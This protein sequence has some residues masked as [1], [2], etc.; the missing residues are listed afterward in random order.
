MPGILCATG[1]C[2]AYCGLPKAR[3]ARVRNTI[4]KGG[5]DA[6]LSG[7]RRGAPEQLD[8]GVRVVNLKATPGGAGMYQSAGFREP[9][10][11]SMRMLLQQLAES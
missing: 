9:A 10:F 6:E 11:P 2:A 4:A 3:K 7:G 1:R 5:D 8:T